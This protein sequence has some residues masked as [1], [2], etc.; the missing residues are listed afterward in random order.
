[1]LYNIE[2]GSAKK[3]CR[4]KLVRDG[5]AVGD[6]WMAESERSIV[7]SLVAAGTLEIDEQTKLEAVA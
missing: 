2:S 5:Q 3:G 1:M 6:L 7:E 4:V